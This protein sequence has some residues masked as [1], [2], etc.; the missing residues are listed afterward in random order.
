[1]PYGS[2]HVVRQAVMFAKPWQRYVI[3]GAMIAGG[4]GLV[5]IGRVSGVLLA[6]A[7]ALL[8]WRMLRYSLRSRR[9]TQRSL[10]AQE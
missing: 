6:A 10:G 5:A 1:M 9:R 8:L 7:G 4:V 2:G 3:A